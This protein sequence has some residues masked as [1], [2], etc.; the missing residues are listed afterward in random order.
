MV[1]DKDLTW[2]D[3]WC[4]PASLVVNGE[5]ISGSY[6]HAPKWQLVKAYSQAP[7]VGFDPVEKYVSNWIFWSGKV[8]NNKSFKPPPSFLPSSN[9]LK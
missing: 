6:L 5:A 8:E 9:Q 1:W 2:H 4:D 3:V 7:V